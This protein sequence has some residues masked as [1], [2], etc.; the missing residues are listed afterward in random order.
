MTCLPT[1]SGKRPRKA[2]TRLPEGWER[3]QEETSFSYHDWNTKTSSKT[4][5]LEGKPP[6]LAQHVGEQRVCPPGLQKTW[7]NLGKVSICYAPDSPVEPVKAAAKR[8]KLPSWVP[9]WCKMT[10]RDPSALL[11]GD[12]SRFSSAG[13]TERIQLPVGGHPDKLV[14]QGIEFD[15]ITQIADPWHPEPGVPPMSRKGIEV[16]QQWEELALSEVAS[17]PYGN[18]QAREAALWRTHI[19]DYP[20]DQAAPDSDHLLL[21][22]WYDR[23]G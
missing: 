4:S 21:E 18:S 3:R 6:S 14:L 1:S 15:K 8:F 10:H 13:G 16:L 5:P 11:E 9:N 23:I 7:D 19:A 17:C 20:G 12:G 22:C 2:W